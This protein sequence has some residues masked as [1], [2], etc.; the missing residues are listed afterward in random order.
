MSFVLPDSKFG[1]TGVNYN[2][3]VLPKAIPEQDALAAANKLNSHRFLKLTNKQ[4]VFVDAYIGFDFDSTKAA[5]ECGFSED[6]AERVGKKLIKRPEI[7]EA[8][9]YALQYYSETT[10][11][12]FEHLVE[13]LKIIALTSI[14]DLVDPVEVEARADVDDDDVRWHAVK[15]IKRTETKYG[16]N[17]EYVM[18]DKLSAIE[19]LLKILSPSQGEPDAPAPGNTTN[20]ITNNNVVQTAIAIVPVP[21]GQFLPPPPSPYATPEAPMIEH[22]SSATLDHQSRVPSIPQAIVLPVGAGR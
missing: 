15:S 6:E 21:S 12:R 17:I 1:M 22:S 3:G 20:N 14:T 9:Q 18:H 19:K 5:L 4:R 13:E 2:L 16:T 7:V 11:L 10:K 8:I